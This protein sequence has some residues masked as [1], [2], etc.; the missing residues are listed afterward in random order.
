MIYVRQSF[1]FPEQEQG[2]SGLRTIFAGLVESTALH[3]F[4]W[5]MQGAALSALTPLID[6]KGFFRDTISLE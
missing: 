4:P 1:P 2:R 6:T 3:Y 5:R